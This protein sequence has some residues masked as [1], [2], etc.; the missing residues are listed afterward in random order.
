MAA[1]VNDSP[2]TPAGLKSAG[3]GPRLA[4]ILIDW[5]LCL[6]IGSLYATPAEAAWPPVVILVVANTLFLGLF[7]QTPGMRLMRIQCA[8]YPAGG[9]IGL[10]NA[11]IRSVLLGLFIPALIMDGQGRGLHDRAAGSIVAAAR[12][13]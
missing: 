9:V 3:L 11:L 7:G 4:A 13:R 5:V 12:R 10:R 1:S 6:L 8:A 2:A